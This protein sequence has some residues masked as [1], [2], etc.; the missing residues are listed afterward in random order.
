M[1]GID[2]LGGLIRAGIEGIQNLG[3]QALKAI[4]NFMKGPMEHPPGD[5]V[6]SSNS[7]PITDPAEILEIA[8]TAEQGGTSEP[9][10]LARPPG[11]EGFGIAKEITALV[12]HKEVD[13]KTTPDLTQAIEKIEELVERESPETIAAVAITLAKDKHGE[14]AATLLSKVDS[15]NADS[16][17]KVVV[18]SIGE[19]LDV[20]V[21]LIRNVSRAEASTVEPGAGAM[22]LRD[23]SIASRL[24]TRFIEKQVGPELNAVLAP[25]AQ[26]V[27]KDLMVYVGREDPDRKKQISPENVQVTQKLVTQTLGAIQDVVKGNPEQ[28]EDQKLRAVKSLIQGIAEDLRKDGWGKIDEG[29]PDQVAANALILRT[30]LPKFS[31]GA[32]TKIEANQMRNLSQV[33]SM[34]AQRAV[35]KKGMDSMGRKPEPYQNSLAPILTSEETLSGIAGIQSALELGAK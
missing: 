6:G 5:A 10:T 29:I 1:S 28:G 2:G 30:A 11:L 14:L 34:V 35:N 32:G 21:A 16:V 23:K 17:A 8:L 22:P 31:T 13:G 27:P 9:T 20:S 19:D 25:I 33:I 7:A 3:S 24:A 4:Q 12:T 15:E 26:Q 18:D